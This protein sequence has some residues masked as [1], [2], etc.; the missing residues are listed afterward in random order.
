MNEDCNFKEAA[1]E[2]ELLVNLLFQTFWELDLVNNKGTQF[3]QSYNYY[4]LY[5]IMS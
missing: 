3:K 2:L 4:T 5:L 1:P